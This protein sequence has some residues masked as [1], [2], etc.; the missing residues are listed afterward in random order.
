MSRYVVDKSAILL[1]VA[2][3]VPEQ[4]VKVL[5]RKIYYQLLYPH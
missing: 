3:T 4:N 5:S 1:L 2:R